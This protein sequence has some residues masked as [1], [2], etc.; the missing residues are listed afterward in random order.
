MRN[1]AYTVFIGIT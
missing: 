1:S